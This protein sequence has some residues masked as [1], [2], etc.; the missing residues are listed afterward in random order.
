MYWTDKTLFLSYMSTP[1][2]YTTELARR[3]YFILE[4][5]V[6]I[7]LFF[8]LFLM[9]NPLV[10]NPDKSN[11]TATGQGI[12]PLTNFFGRW[13]HAFFGF[14]EDR[15]NSNHAIIYI[16]GICAFLCLFALERITGIISRIII[17]LIKIVDNKGSSSDQFSTNLLKEISFEDL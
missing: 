15:F 13:A 12:L 14:K 1:P 3:A 2:K 4:W 5:A 16:T 9:T 7:H 17:R 8:G 6:V 11:I 10:F